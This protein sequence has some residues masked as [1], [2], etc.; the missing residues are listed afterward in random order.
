MLTIAAEYEQVPGMTEALPEGTIV[1]GLD[2]SEDC[3]EI[4]RV[5]QDLATALGQR[6]EFVHALGDGRRHAGPETRAMLD[7]LCAAGGP[8]VG[9]RI[10]EGDP[11]RR[12]AAVAAEERA[13]LIVVGTRGPVPSEGAPLGSISRRLAAGAPCPVLIVPRSVQSHVRPLG[14]RAR[15]I[16]CG[17]D[18]SDGAWEAALQAAELAEGLHARVVLVSVGATVPWKMSGVARELAARRPLVRIDW[19]HHNGDPAWELQRSAAT[20]TA[21]LIAVG[22]HGAGPGRERLLLGSVARQL[23]LTAR[24]PVLTVPIQTLLP[25]R[26]QE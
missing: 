8:G 6:L 21:A 7:M 5:A 2:G 17:F 19:E 3:L 15:S 18:A 13:A 9:G 10:V 14:W 20:N 4:A 16:V 25:V 22:S 26:M 12:I 11:M 23:L 24:L 1:C